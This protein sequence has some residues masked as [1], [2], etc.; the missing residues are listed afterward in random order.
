MNDVRRK[1]LPYALRMCSTLSPLCYPC[2]HEGSIRSLT[3][4]TMFLR[5]NI[6]GHKLLIY[7]IAT[8]K[9]KKLNGQFYTL[10]VFYV[11]RREMIV[12]TTLSVLL[13]RRVN[14]LHVV[15]P[16]TTSS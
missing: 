15:A 4:K 7:K 9:A 16:Y 8:D 12:A 2:L 11:I 14:V 10:S 3:T 5:P 13:L 1:L 6:D